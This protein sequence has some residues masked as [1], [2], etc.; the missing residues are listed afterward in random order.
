MMIITGLNISQG[1]GDNGIRIQRICLSNLRN[2]AFILPREELD[3]C[4]YYNYFLRFNHDYAS[5]QVIH[6][7]TLP[8]PMMKDFICKLKI[9][10]PKSS[11]TGEGS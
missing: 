6:T 5:M 2:E 9:Y 4:D 8:F 3:D 10:F 1:S 7:A 11:A